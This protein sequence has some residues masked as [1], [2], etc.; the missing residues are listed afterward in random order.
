MTIEELKT[1]FVANFSTFSISTL[2]Y[3]YNECEKF[4]ANMI[5]VDPII[6]DLMAKLEQEIK[7]RG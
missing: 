4:I 6:F 5:A 3:Y 2:E 1:L 7:N